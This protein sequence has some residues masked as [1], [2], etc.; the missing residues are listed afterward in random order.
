MKCKWC[1]SEN[2]KFTE[3]RESIH[4]GRNDCKDC[5]KWIEWVKN[6]ES[7]RTKNPLRKMKLSPEKVCLFHKFKTTHC[8]FCQ[9]GKEELGYNETLTVDHIEELDKGGK[10]EIENQQ[11]LCSACH[12]MKNWLRLYMNWHLKEELK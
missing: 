6:P 12:K 3:T 5:G 11:V 4:Y 2:I 7:N 1:G 10:D 9:R 8:F